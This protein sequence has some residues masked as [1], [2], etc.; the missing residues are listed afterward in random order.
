MLVGIAATLIAK[1]PTAADAALHAKTDSA[2]LWTPRGFFD[3][4]VGPFVEFFSTHK[5]FGLVMLLTITLYHLSDYL[6]GPIVN[7]FLHDAG[8]SKVEIGAMRA[9]FGLWSTVA[10]VAAGGFCSLRIGFFKTLII[11]AIL[12]PI[13]IGGFALVALSGGSLPLFGVVNS[14][15]DFA[16]GFSGVA[17]VSY[18]SSLT[19]LGYTAS[20]YAVMSSA[21]AWTGKTLKGFTGFVVQWLQEGRDLMHAYALF[22]LGI[23]ALGIPAILLCLVLK[24]AA[25]R[26]LASAA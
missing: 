13:G 19:S 22:Y 14:I 16:I 3:A 4:V 6:R 8:F 25:D 5:A 20:Q 12:Q 17:L 24:R 15:D 10:G 11:G 7:P 18:M 9:T 21:L 26:R 1:E 2:P 23:A